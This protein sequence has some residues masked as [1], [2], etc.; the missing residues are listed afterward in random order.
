MDNLDHSILLLRRHLVVAGEAQASF[1]DIRADVDAGSG[2]VGIA[3]STAVAFDGDEGVGAV[4][5]LH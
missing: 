5:R 1:E 4:D 2:D 3:L